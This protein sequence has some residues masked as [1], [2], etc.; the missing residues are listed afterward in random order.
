VDE[1]R[2][3]AEGLIKQLTGGDKVTARLLYK[4]FFE[5]T[6]QFTLWLAANDRPYVRASDSGMWRRILQLPFTHAI[7]EGERDP[8]LKHRLKNDPEARSAILTWV[9]EGCLAWQQ[10]GLQIPD[11]V[12]SYT[13]EYRS[14]VDPLTEFLDEHC[15][16][17]PT[18]RTTRG[19]LYTAY[20]RWAH[21][22][23]TPPITQKAFADALKRLGTTDG[24]KSAG[25]RHWQGI[26]LIASDDDNHES[27]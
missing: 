5:F 23:G 16:L 14:E 3:L 19:A 27:F 20:T 26:E 22:Y 8:T 24:G 25:I 21:G 17:N 2:E 7:P 18:A 11:R 10:D 13:E 6:P 12:R 1:G 15:Q 4:E 9:V